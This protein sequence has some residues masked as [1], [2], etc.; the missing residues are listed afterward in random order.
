MQLGDEE[1]LAALQSK[2]APA[3]TAAATPGR[4]KAA[5]KPS[6]KRGA[7]PREVQASDVTFEYAQSL[8]V[9]PIA[10]GEVDGV[11]V[12]VNRG[13]FGPFVKFGEVNATIPKA[14][15]PLKVDLTQALALVEAKKEREAK[16]LAKLAAASSPAASAAVTTT[17][18]PVTSTVAKRRAS[19]ARKVEEGTETEREE[20]TS[21][22]VEEPKKRGGRKKKEEATVAVAVT[23]P[24]VETKPK[25]RRNRS[26]KAEAAD[27]LP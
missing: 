11:P 15:D 20:S 25:T 5:A 10:L 9:Y 27:A 12:S 22:A 1:S 13:M 23:E 26:T 2:M 19:T 8:L 6:F 7:V 14:I 21:V 24:A 18:V 3:V 17:A 16:K 4:K